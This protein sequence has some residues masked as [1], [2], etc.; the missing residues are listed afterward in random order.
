MKPIAIIEVMETGLKVV[1]KY[2]VPNRRTSLE[3]EIVCVPGMEDNKPRAIELVKRLRREKKKVRGKIIQFTPSAQRRL[4]DRLAQLIRS[5]LPLFV[6]LTFPDAFPDFKEAKRCLIRFRLRAMRAFPGHGVV[7]KMEI[8]ERKSGVN[9]GKWVPHFHLLVYGANERTFK[10]WAHKAWHE[11]A[12]NDDPYHRR[13]GVKVKQAYEIGRGRSFRSYLRKYMGKIFEAPSDEGIGKLWDTWGNVPFGEV[14]R[15]EVDLGVALKLL[16]IMMSKEKAHR[17][18]LR[19]ICNMWRIKKNPP[20]GQ[21]FFDI[22]D[23]EL[24]LA[25]VDLCIDNDVPF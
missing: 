12:G 19:E 4:R 1:P 10:R 24:F 18:W 15:I 7:W 6:T 11:I 9:I 2:D 5:V 13:W 25:L 14:R 23:P 3:D 17:R 20:G 8:V 16:R 21:R 22:G